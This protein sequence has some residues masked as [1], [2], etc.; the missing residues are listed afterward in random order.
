MKFI[1]FIFVGG[2]GLLINLGITYV[3]TQY[4]GWWYLLS[5]I[6]GT[7]ASWNFVFFT[8]SFFT[9]AGHSKENY[10]RKYVTFMVGYS[11]SLIINA[12]LVFF[13]TSI[14]HVYYLFS[15]IFATII[16][17]LYTFFFSKRI[18]YTS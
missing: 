2:C 10:F 16:T 11:G 4:A 18:V 17:T 13:C 6:V 15:I 8:N 12:G 9:F 7:F 5:Y 14:L 3:L 1:Q